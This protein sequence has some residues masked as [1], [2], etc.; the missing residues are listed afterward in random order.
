MIYYDKTNISIFTLGLILF[1]IGFGI[2]F[3]GD[4]S[5]NDKDTLCKTSTALYW[6]GIGLLVLATFVRFS[7][8]FAINKY[9]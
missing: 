9:F 8:F 6:T 4:C 3:K 2:S 5:F 7:K 1:F